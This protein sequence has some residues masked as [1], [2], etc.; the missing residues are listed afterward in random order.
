MKKSALIVIVAVVVGLFFGFLWGRSLTPPTQIVSV[1]S[2]VAAAPAIVPHTASLMIDYGDGTV[3]TYIGIPL[4]DNNESVL[5]VLYDQVKLAGLNIET[6]DYGDMG[7]LI[8]KI[9][10]KTNGDGG[11]YWQYWVNNVSITR[12]ASAYIVKPG[13]VI[14]WKFLHYK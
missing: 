14:E 11:K 2:S 9:G 10:S 3:R 13:D 4:S 12:A 1:D 7:R 5:N 8:T 6:K